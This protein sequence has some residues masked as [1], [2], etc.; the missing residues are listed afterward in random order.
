MLFR[1]FYIH[2]PEQQSFQQLEPFAMVEVTD[3]VGLVS[4]RRRH[5][6]SNSVSSSRAGD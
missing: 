3:V 6:A 5:A 2:G 1:T 4:S